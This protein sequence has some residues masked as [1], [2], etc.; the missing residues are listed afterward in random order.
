[1]LMLL[2]NSNVPMSTQPKHL[3][4]KYTPGDFGC[5]I[6]KV[7]LVFYRVN[8]LFYFIIFTLFIFV[9]YF[10]FILFCNESN[11]IFRLFLQVLLMNVQNVHHLHGTKVFLFFLAPNFFALFIYFKLGIG[12][13]SQVP[14]ALLLLHVVS[15]CT[16]HCAT[17]YMHYYR[18]TNKIL[19]VIHDVYV[20]AG[21]ALYLWLSL[22]SILCLS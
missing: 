5:N 20:K 22:F 10:T 4:G 3:P 19:A 18:I 11:I 13:Q 2:S 12:I 1:M 16:A 17:T 9:F 15:M 21:C 8:Y 14:R 6:L 7:F